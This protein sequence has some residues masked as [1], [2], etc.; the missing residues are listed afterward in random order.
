MHLAVELHLCTH[1]VMKEFIITK[2]SLLH[3]YF[4]SFMLVL[5]LS[6]V[7]SVDV[8]E[9]VQDKQDALWLLLITK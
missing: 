9:D 4:T 3:G 2:W 8:L 7:F 6:C 1:V 5:C